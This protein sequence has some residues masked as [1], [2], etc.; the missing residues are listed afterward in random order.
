MSML[1]TCC[2]QSALNGPHAV[3]TTRP[4]LLP[5]GSSCSPNAPL[6]PGLSTTHPTPE[7][8]SGCVYLQ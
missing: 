7:A 5:G 2:A 3:N 6:Q 8:V 4:C 1:I